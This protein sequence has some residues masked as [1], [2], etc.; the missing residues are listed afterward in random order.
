MF[1]DTTRDYFQFK[2]SDVPCTCDYKK[3]YICE[4]VF[5][6]GKDVIG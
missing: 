5:E 6:S 3:S 2:W 1:G 4:A